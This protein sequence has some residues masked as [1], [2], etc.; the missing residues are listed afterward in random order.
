[1]AA[2]PSRRC[3]TPGLWDA[4]QPT[5]VLGENVSQAAQFATSGSAQGGIIAYSLAL[6]PE[7]GEA[8][9]LRAASRRTGTQPLRQRMV[10]LKARRRDAAAFYAYMQRAGR[11]ARSSQRYGFVLPGEAS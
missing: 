7:V 11:R 9:Q 4:L 6:A 8:R 10:L 5:L 1:M 2:R 3:A